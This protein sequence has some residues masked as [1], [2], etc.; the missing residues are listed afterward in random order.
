MAEAPAPN[1][2]RA[3]QLK[4]LLNEAVAL[5]VELLSA[6]VRIW[7]K[8]FES[9]AEYTKTASE[10]LTRLSFQGDANAALDRVMKVARDRLDELEK[11]PE[12]IGADFVQKVRT[13][14]RV[15]V[16]S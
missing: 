16:K 6:A 11:L 4:N 14:A 3:D 15:K 7:S 8:M 2:E 10:E 13:R 5:Q 9:M 12:Q 1:Q